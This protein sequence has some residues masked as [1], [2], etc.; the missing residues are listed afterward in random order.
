MLCA[1]APREFGCGMG[2][3][4]IVDEV[5]ARGVPCFQG[6]CSEMYL[7]KALDNTGWRPAERLPVAQ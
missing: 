4:R 1:G 7:E 2:W 5:V 3:D 6:S